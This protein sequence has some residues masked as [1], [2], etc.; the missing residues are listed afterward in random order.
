ME[1]VEQFLYS[2]GKYWLFEHWQEDGKNIYSKAKF[3]SFNELKRNAE[4]LLTPSQWKLLE[5]DKKL[6][7][8]KEDG[9]TLFFKYIDL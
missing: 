8:K 3:N 7:V 4:K 5:I 2:K 6:S 9:T 1:G